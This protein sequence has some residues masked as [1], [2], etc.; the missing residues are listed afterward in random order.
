MFW[1]YRSIKC[2]MN[3][4]NSTYFSYGPVVGSEFIWDLKKKGNCLIFVLMQPWY[5]FPASVPPDHARI[6][7]LAAEGD[8]LYTGLE[9][10]LILCIH[11]TD[12]SISLL[13][14]AYDRAVHSLMIM[15]PM[16]I[17]SKTSP[18]KEKI[19]R[20]QAT[21]KG[22][23][24]NLPM[25]NVS[26]SNPRNNLLSN[27]PFARDSL[28]LSPMSLSV[29]SGYKTAENVLL[30]SIGTG[31]RGIVGSHHNHP[32]DFILPSATPLQSN[33][34]PAIP[35]ASR[36]HLLVWSTENC[37][38]TG[39]RGEQEMCNSENEEDLDQLE[40]QTQNHEHV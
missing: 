6:T 12:M 2:Q 19:S 11:C 14:S 35:E 21:R 22:R 16:K 40:H 29:N 25:K 36:N 18:R 20:S 34:K 23:P 28:M 37:E 17:T 24:L 33:S 39:E 9:N 31:Y 1:V 10:G 38:E 32:G 13:F 26:L 8:I 4:D 3:S 7:S 30:L 5:I 15:Q 27:V